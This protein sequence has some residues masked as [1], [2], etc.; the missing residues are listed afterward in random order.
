MTASAQQ[1]IATPSLTST[2]T[3]YTTLESLL[4]FHNLSAHGTDPSSFSDISNLLVKN[5]LVR[6]SENFDRGRLSPDA[7]QEFYLYLLRREEAAGAGMNGVSAKSTAMGNGSTN[8]GTGDSVDTAN[9]TRKM[10]ERF[11][12]EYRERLRVLIKA[13]EDR[14]TKLGDEIKEIEKG[15]WDD[16]LGVNANG[17]RASQRPT[18]PSTTPVPNP[19][20]IPGDQSQNVI[21]TTNT[22]LPVPTEPAVDSKPATPPPPPLVASPPPA[23]PDLAVMLPFVQVVEG[24]KPPTS[25][26]APAPNPSPCPGPSPTLSAAPAPG[27]CPPSTPPPAPQTV[28]SSVLTT[29]QPSPQQS[30]TPHLAPQ[31]HESPVQQQ[32]SLQQRSPHPVQQAQPQHHPQPRMS[33]VQVLA[34]RVPAIQS[35]PQTMASPQP[36]T[37]QFHPT[38]SAAYSPISHSPTSPVPG[39]GYPAPQSH[40]QFHPSVQLPPPVPHPQSPYRMAAGYVGV[41]GADLPPQYHQL[42]QLVPRTQQAQDLQRSQYQTQQ[43]P[44]PPIHHQ[45]QQI[46]PPPTS[47]SQTSMQSP[48]R[49]PP[50]PV[51]LQSPPPTQTPTRS[52]PLLQQLQGLPQS[53]VPITSTVPPKSPPKHRPPPIK[54]D[55]LPLAMPPLDQLQR[56]PQMPVLFQVQIPKADILPQK[57]APSLTQSP[58]R[59]GSPIQPG[60]DEISPISTPG[61]SPSPPY[62]SELE[63]PPIGKKRS[64]EDDHEIRDVRHT[65]AAQTDRQTPDAEVGRPAHKRRKSMGPATSPTTTTKSTPKLRAM[66]TIATAADR[67]AAARAASAAKRAAAKSAKL[68][69]EKVFMAPKAPTGSTEADV[70]KERQSDAEC[71]EEDTKM[72]EEDLE[73]EEEEVPVEM[74][75]K[76]R[77]PGKKR[78]SIVKRRQSV[79]KSTVQQD[80]D[81]DETADDISTV[82]S[83]VTAPT[84]ANGEENVSDMDV[85]MEVDSTPTP[86]GRGQSKRK[87]QGSTPPP[88]EEATP[89]PTAS[90]RLSVTPLAPPPPPLV[91]QKPDAASTSSSS[92]LSQIIA[93]SP[94]PVSFLPP[95]PVSTVGQQVQ[96]IATKKFQQLSAPL[97]HNISAHRFANLFMAPVGERVAPGYSRLVYRPMDLKTIK[98]AIKNGA[99]AVNQ[100]T[101]ASTTTTAIVPP[102]G[103]VNSAQLERELFRMFANAVMYNKSNTEIVKETVEM[104][105]EVERRV[106]L[107]GEG[108]RERGRRL[109]RLRRLRK[110][111]RKEGRVCGRRGRRKMR[112]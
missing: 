89:I 112:R 67:T 28:Q 20:D 88:T 93:P 70:K 34:Q 29:T 94:S 109:R 104:G 47:P 39:H 78:R 33:P 19:V 3:A 24:L 64:F 9:F 75:I 66:S 40:Q 79:K 101:A 25:A 13:D 83:E 42:P 48:T 100:L 1:Q 6:E 110:K 41:T 106:S 36:A 31:P 62:F 4:L 51:L 53:L 105:K 68:A 73:E 11:F 90:P 27:P 102:K 43:Q 46:Q 55:A 32:N 22:D 69:A 63:P 5:P 50:P 26:P 97:L 17:D 21:Q 103:I 14:Y 81:K 84:A 12:A 38:T 61:S 82:E 80:E 91:Q 44:L 98:A 56:P 57:A 71:V 85:D 59:P 95:R 37:Q 111:I 8:G 23:P 16:R 15:K 99:T 2:N 45:P 87:R 92:S 7:L 108:A 60:P 76:R 49:L 86:K 107:V 18:P 30:P 77:K 35:P 96:V 65:P 74:V 10:R 54:T 52:P 58:T 72:G